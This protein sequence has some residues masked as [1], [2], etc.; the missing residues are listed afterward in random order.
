MHVY[1]NASVNKTY[2][3]LINIYNDALNDSQYMQNS[4]ATNEL[5]KSMISLYL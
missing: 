5:H 2:I 4:L 3:L 1:E